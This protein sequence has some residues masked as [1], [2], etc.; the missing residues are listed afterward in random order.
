LITA[1]LVSYRTPELIVAAIAV[2]AR[3]KHVSKILVVDNSPGDGSAEAIRAKFPGV[4][5]ITM[6]E[7]VG[8]ARAVNTALEV[9][10]SDNH[11]ML[12]NP[13]CVVG[14]SGIGEMLSTLENDPTVGAV[15]PLLE[16]PGSPGRALSAGYQPTLGRIFMHYWGI[17]ALMGKHRW[18]HGWHLQRPFDSS[19]EAEVEWASGA[20]LIIRDVTL[21]SVGHLD[22]RWFMFAEDMDYCR[23][24]RDRGWRII[25]TPRARG[26]HL[27]G[28]STPNSLVSTRWVSALIDYYDIRLSPSIGGTILYRFVLATGLAARGVLAARKIFSKRTREAAIIKVEKNLLWARRAAFPRRHGLDLPLERQGR[29][30]LI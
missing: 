10:G 24:I 18:A 7:N 11:V 14:E 27:I 20:C 9:A 25:H 5:I 8:F 4:E 22:E 28:A 6:K 17:S 30:E 21:E 26:T 19:Q 23:R 13:D 15:A 29:R 2:L 12:V 1:V 16:V 3:S